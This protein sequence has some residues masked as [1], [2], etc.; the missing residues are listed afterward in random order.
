MRSLRLSILKQLHFS[1]GVLVNVTAVSIWSRTVRLCILQPAIC[2]INWT[3]RFY[4]VLVNAFCSLATT[5]IVIEWN[6]C[7]RNNP[8][9]RW[10]KTEIDW[11]K[12][13]SRIIITNIWSI[14][15][16][17]I[18]SMRM[19]RQNG[20]WNFTHWHFPPKRMDLSFAHSVCTNDSWAV[21]WQTSNI[22][23]NLSERGISCINVIVLNFE[24]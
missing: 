6:K 24:P 11:L 16:K 20:S 19:Q 17:M 23:F 12:T 22:S 3:F 10:K 5:L 13:P 21:Q 15:Y 7:T 14:N 2:N 18:Y 1:A 4:W 8:L 9:K